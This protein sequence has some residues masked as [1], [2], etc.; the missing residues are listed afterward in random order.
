MERESLYMQFGWLNFIGDDKV[1]IGVR[2]DYQ[3]KGVHALIFSK[4]R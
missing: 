2:P 1:L 4:I 3:N